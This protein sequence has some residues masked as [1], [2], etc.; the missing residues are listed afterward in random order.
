[1][2]TI[3]HI[4]RKTDWEQARAEGSYRADT[5]ASE[6]FIHCS[7]PEQVI[8]VANHL[9]RGQPDLVLLVID[10]DKVRAPIRDENLEGGT[11]LYPHIYGPLNLDAVRSVLDFPP[12]ADGSFELPIRHGL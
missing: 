10:R 5:L 7:T 3:L 11:T 1:M 12:R 8:P 9:F 2:T 6:G 4:A